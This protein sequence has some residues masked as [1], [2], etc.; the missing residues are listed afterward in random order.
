M[1][2]G[3]ASNGAL[4]AALSTLDRAVE[5]QYQLAPCC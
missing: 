4:A 3:M 5:E 2:S 1:R